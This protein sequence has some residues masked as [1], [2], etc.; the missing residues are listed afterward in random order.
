MRAP[1]D[2][3]FVTRDAQS[4]NLGEVR[5]GVGVTPVPGSSRAY[6]RRM[7]TTSIGR[8]LILAAGITVLAACASKTVTDPP[9]QTPAVEQTSPTDAALPPVPLTRKGIVVPS[10][11]K[12]APAPPSAT[13]PAPAITNPAPNAN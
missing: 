2:A 7:A 11:V 1:S 12:L 5:A 3:H 9:P 10:D 8:Q 13:P 6:I 4:S